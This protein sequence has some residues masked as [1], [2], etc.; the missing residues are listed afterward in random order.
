M[1]IQLETHEK[2]S[3]F[4]NAMCNGL[5]NIGYWEF[6]I[7]YSQ[8]DYKSA[9]QSL[10]KK[11]NSSICL[12]DVYMEMLKMGKTIEFI[13]NGCEGEY[14][15]SLSLEMVYNNIE[16]TPIDNLLNVIKEQDDSCDA[17]AILQSVLF[18]EIIFG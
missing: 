7:D 4:Y 11:G 5:F 10:V 14:N 9:R 13:D 8:N 18:E 16:K 2:E 15:R 12:E 1:N 6:Q 17:D 3:I